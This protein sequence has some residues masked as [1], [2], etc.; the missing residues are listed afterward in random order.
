M[1]KIIYKLLFICLVSSACKDKPIP[2][3]NPIT[4]QPTT[5]TREVIVFDYSIDTVRCDTGR[6]KNI[7]YNNGQPTLP[8]G[9]S[10]IAPDV[11]GLCI[12]RIN[13][14]EIFYSYIGSSTLI[15]LNHITKTKST[16]PLTVKPFY[17]STNSDGW[18]LFTRPN[19]IWKA[20][21]NG[22]SLKYLVDGANVIAKWNF[23]GSKFAFY[24]EMTGST[25]CIADRNGLILDSIKGEPAD[26]FDWSKPDTFVRKIR[27]GRIIA[28][29]TKDR[30]HKLLVSPLGQS[31]GFC[32]L[33]D[34]KTMVVA[35]TNGLYIFDTETQLYRKIRCTAM[36]NSWYETPTYSRKH[37]KIFAIKYQLRSP[38]DYITTIVSMNIDGSDEKQVD[39]R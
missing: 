9:L 13:E 38:Y 33:G 18:L 5:E 32:W 30:S 21:I 6:F 16:V 12:N 29:N 28:Y 17:Y 10:P 24:P 14:D 35:T 27:D 2:D 4:P 23:D 7:L 15:S 8:V 25:F 34:F 31:S 19:S 20:K 1:K 26:Y 36:Y 37:K 3:V 22:D 11:A 39:I